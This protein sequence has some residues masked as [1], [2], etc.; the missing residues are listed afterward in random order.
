[1]SVAP[2]AIPRGALLRLGIAIIALAATGWL[3]VRTAPRMWREHQRRTTLAHCAGSSWS[4]PRVATSLPPGAFLRSPTLAEAGGTLYVSG[5]LSLAGRTSVA[6]DSTS[7][8]AR[9]FGADG[10]SLGLPTGQFQFENARLL[11]DG[12]ARLHLM[13]GERGPPRA[14]STS[15]DFGPPVRVRSLWHSVF[16]PGSGW[17]PA[18][19]VFFH[20]ADRDGLLWNAENSSVAVAASGRVHLAVPRVNR[21]L[22][23]LSYNEGA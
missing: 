14:R 5:I 3:G 19:L 4:A 16:I 13:W 10:R 17:S 2:S 11:S 6:M 9:V 22:L 8:S 21:D 23:V 1:V 20:R 7:L 18:R 15:R 12:D